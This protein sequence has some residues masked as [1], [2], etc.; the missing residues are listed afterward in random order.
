MN[1]KSTIENV[2]IVDADYA[3]GV[4]FNLIVN[5]ERML[6]RRIPQAD[7]ARWAECVALDGGVRASDPAAATL[8]ETQVV[9]V[10]N[11][12]KQQLDN[13]TPAVYATDLNGQAFKGS[14]GEFS[15]CAVSDEGLATKDDLF[16]DTL[17]TVAAYKGLKRLMVIPDERLLPQ[18]RSVLARLDDGDLRITVFTMQP[19]TGGN[20]RQEIL[21]YSLM[22]A[23]G[24]HADEISAALQS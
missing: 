3:D 4:A 6:G 5:F 11:H 18:L 19:V 7:M 20:F 17:Q 16:V 10:H 21:G 1:Q 14:L 2:I 12:Q 24:I 9:L 13:F 23:L 15:F 22:Q 8:P